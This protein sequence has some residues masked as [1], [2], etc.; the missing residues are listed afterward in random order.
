M[1]L[2]IS[3]LLLISILFGCNTAKTSTQTKEHLKIYVCLS[4]E[5]AKTRMT[6]YELSIPDTWCSYLGMHYMLTHSPKALLD[7]RNNEHT[8][9]LYVI[10]YDAPSHQSEN[11]EEALKK[12]L[13]S[14]VPSL[15]EP[16]Y[17]SDIHN[18]YGKYYIIKSK[19]VY[20]GSIIVNLDILFN[21]NKQ[22]YIINYNV[23]EKDYE[24]YVNDVLKIVASF[25]VKEKP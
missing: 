17:T 16:V 13:I 4:P 7:L 5:T 21:Y 20:D 12:Q 6:N 15:Y 9:S 19:S 10:S 24:T 8:N 2:N 3:V 1:K 23:L 11:I 22:D 25:R 18:V 14:G